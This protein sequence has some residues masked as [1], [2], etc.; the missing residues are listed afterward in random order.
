MKQDVSPDTVPFEQLRP[1]AW[2]ND[3]LRA[4]RQLTGQ[5][6]AN[7]VLSAIIVVL[8]AVVIYLALFRQPRP[9]V[10]EVD[11]SGTVR[12]GGFISAGALDAEQYIPSQ[13]MAFVEHWRTVTPDNTMQKRNIQRLYCMAPRTS[14]TYTRLNEY[15]R[16]PGSDPFKRNV[17]VSVSTRIRQISKLGG[18]TYQVEWYET[19]RDHEGE[20]LG[21]TALHKA[22]MIIEPRAVDADCIEGN[23]L[24]VYVMDLNWT[25]VQ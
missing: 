21:N 16:S 24:G 7:V 15:F 22:T 13:I 5:V 17:T 19:D 20:Q 10:L 18:R 14:P 8:V 1:G 11:D 25:E 9:Y 4:Q 23:P 2:A 12:F 3:L 6:T